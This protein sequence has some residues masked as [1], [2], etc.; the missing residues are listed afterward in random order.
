M[1]LISR[2]MHLICNNHPP[3]A[4]E[5]FEQEGHLSESDCLSPCDDGSVCCGALPEQ[6]AIC[7]AEILLG[8][9][10]ALQG[11]GWE[12]PM[13]GLLLGSAQPGEHCFLSGIEGRTSCADQNQSL[14]CFPQI[15][16]VTW[17]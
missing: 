4:G 5:L 13:E 7:G 8:D 9:V 14:Q 16:L 12:R 6:T 17:Q 15:I 10:G 11:V 2:S 3:K 1:A